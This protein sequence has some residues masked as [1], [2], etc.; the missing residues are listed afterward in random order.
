MG[1]E[2]HDDLSIFSSC[3]EKKQL[4]KDWGREFLSP[5]VWCTNKNLNIHH[6]CSSQQESCRVLSGD[7]DDMPVE[8][9]VFRTQ[10]SSLR[11]SRWTKRSTWSCSGSKCSPGSRKIS[12]KTTS[13]YTPANHPE[14]VQSQFPKYKSNWTPSS[15][16]WWNWRSD[17]SLTARHW[18]PSPP[19]P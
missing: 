3:L 7:I 8:K 15:S 12:R 14:V 10:T 1:R 5:V 6:C 13:S 11:A 17:Y 2:I 18:T 16:V 19:P 9:S 4:L